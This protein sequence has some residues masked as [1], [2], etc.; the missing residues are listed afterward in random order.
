MQISGCVGSVHLTLH[1]V[2]GSSVPVCLKK[3]Q[4]KTSKCYKLLFMGKIPVIFLSYF[5]ILISFCQIIHNE[6]LPQHL[7]NIHFNKEN[8]F[9]K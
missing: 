3:F 5:I 9:K 8:V 6:P 7:K 4:K 2:Q 1:F